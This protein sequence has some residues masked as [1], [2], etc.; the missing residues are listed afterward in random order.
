MQE[1]SIEDWCEYFDFKNY[2]IIN[3]VVNVNNRLNLCNKILDKI[4]VKFAIVTG[5]FDCSSNNLLTL[6]GGPIEVGGNY[7]CG[8]N[9][10]ITLEYGPIKLGGGFHCSGNP[11]YE[12][13]SKYNNYTQYMR[14]VKLRELLCKN[15]Q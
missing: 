5:Y 8:F 4:P 14:S 15:D 2:D 9:Q 6:E 3:D 10:L 7:F 11:V 12:E 13:Y 1:R